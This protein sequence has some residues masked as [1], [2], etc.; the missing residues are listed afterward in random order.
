MRWTS[1]IALLAALVVGHGQATGNGAALQTGRPA[2]RGAVD[3]VTVNVTATDGSHRYVN[4]LQR[5]EFLVFE[6]GRKQEI[7]FFQQTGIPLAV[8]LLLDTSASMDRT[9]R[10]AQKAAIGFVRELSVMDA[11]TVIDFGSRVRVRQGFTDD[12]A[13]LETAIQQTRAGGSTA[14]YNA[15]YIAI[16]EVSKAPA[17]EG[18]AEPRRRAIVVLSDGD[19]TSSIV[20]FEEV[21]EQAIRLDTAIYAIGLLE[22]NSSKARRSRDAKFVLRQLAH[23]TGGR[24]FFPT[25]ADAFAGIYSD[26]KADLS[27]QYSVAYESDNPLRDG[28]FRRIGVRIT[29]PGI[30]ARARP[31]YYA[32]TK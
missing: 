17:H 14:L 12:M 8:A 2:F 11:A 4:D 24:S 29:R 3:V 18:A 23:Q 30:T 13:A 22:G 28:K 21:L 32:P 31:G 20:S 5:D 19:D 16:K 1:T 26:I 9:L 6:D 15:L 10:V 25:D 27:S 7:A